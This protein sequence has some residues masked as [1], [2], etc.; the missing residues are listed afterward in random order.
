MGLSAVARPCGDFDGRIG[1]YRVAHDR[2]ALRDNKYHKRR[3]VYKVD[4]E[5]EADLFYNFFTFRWTERARTYV[6]GTICRKL[7]QRE[8]R[9]VASRRC[10]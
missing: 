8:D 3:D 10:V 2:F 5:M 4:C 7:E 9:L 6:H 1:L